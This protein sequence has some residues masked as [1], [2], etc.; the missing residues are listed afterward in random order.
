M[1]PVR[2]CSLGPK[3]PVA[4]LHRAQD[5][6]WVCDFPPVATQEPSWNARMARLTG[7]GPIPTLQ[8]GRD[9]GLMQHRYRLTCGDGISPDAVRLEMGVL[10]MAW[11]WPPEGPPEGQLGSLAL[12][13]PLAQ[14]AMACCGGCELHAEAVFCSGASSPP[15]AVHNVLYAPLQ[16]CQALWLGDAIHILNA[17]VYPPLC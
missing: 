9:W 8:S 3:A 5:S 17:C 15:H 10:C 13:P 14:C 16:T 2:R 7:A 11:P 6:L 12:C 4:L 1:L